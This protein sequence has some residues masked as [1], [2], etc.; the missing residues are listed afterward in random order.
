MS[1]ALRGAD[2]DDRQFIILESNVFSLKGR[3]PLLLNYRMPQAAVPPS[4]FAI[5]F[6]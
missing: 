3:L 1:A 4:N 2:Q 5:A 6:T